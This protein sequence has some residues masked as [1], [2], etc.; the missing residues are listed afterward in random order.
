MHSTSSSLQL[1][2]GAPCSTTL[3][4]TFLARQQAHAFDALLFAGLPEGLLNPAVEAFRFDDIWGF[5]DD[6]FAILGGIE[7]APL[8]LR[9]ELVIATTQRKHEDSNEETLKRL[10]N[11]GVWDCYIDPACHESGALTTQRSSC[12][13]AICDI[14]SSQIEIIIASTAN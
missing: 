13:L 7:R 14:S 1:V 11:P 6:V 2:Q 5:A 9:S 12:F 4:R 3:Q 8:C 10:Q